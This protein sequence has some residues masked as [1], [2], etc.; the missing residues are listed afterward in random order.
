MHETQRVSAQQGRDTG[1]IAP[2][3]IYHIEAEHA[4]TAISQAVWAFHTKH[5][6]FPA[7]VGVNLARWQQ[8]H[9][10]IWL[11]CYYARVGEDVRKIPL[12]VVA[13]NPCDVFCQA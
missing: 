1:A 7:W 5:G 2:V 4:L 13:V 6:R 12:R 11:C 10:E 9:V 3:E 8:Y